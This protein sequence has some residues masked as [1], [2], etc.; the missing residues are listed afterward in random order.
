MEDAPRRGDED[1]I[2][3]AMV[4]AQE[5]AVRVLENALGRH[6]SRFSILVT[7]EYDEVG[8]KNLVFDIEAYRARVDKRKLEEVIEAAIQAAVEV[9]EKKAGVRV[10]KKVRRRSK[11]PL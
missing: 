7:V 5:E 3:E 9:F 1:K 10:G 4:A 11:T 6:A 8:P 2:V